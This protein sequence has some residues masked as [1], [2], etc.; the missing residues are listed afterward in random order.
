M[1]KGIRL[2]KEAKKYLV[3]GVDSPVRSFNKVGRPPIPIK[4][5]RGP[6]VWDYDGGKYIDYCLSWGSLILGHSHPAVV[7]K[8]KARIKEGLSFGA[9]NETEVKLARLVQEAIP[10]VEKIR[11][12]NSGTEAV[13]GAV[14]LSRGYTRKDKIIKFSNA[15]HGHADYLLTES[16][17]IPKD[18]LRHTL[19]VPY[20]DVRAVKDIFKRHDGSIAAVLVE[21]VA[22]NS[23]VVRPDINFLYAIRG[24]TVKYGA[25][26]IFDEVITAFRSGFGSAAGEFGITPDLICLGKVIGGGLPIGAFGGKKVIMDKLAPLG[27]VYQAGTFSGNPVVMQAGITTLEE[28]RRISHGYYRVRAFTKYLSLAIEGEAKKRGVD[29]QAPYW[30][31]MFSIKFKDERRFKKFYGRMISEGVYFAPSQFEANFL[32]FSHTEK[33]IDKTIERISI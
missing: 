13:M 26:L 16:A 11:F 30:G 3:G 15:Y 10:F 6:Y 8:L 22:G 28:L 23:G 32:S 7:D 29:L 5:G 25:V 9:T 12:A 14:R 19:I 2:F 21:P 31:T 18:F 1:D 4:R 27:N 33:E 24:L 17:G 20:G